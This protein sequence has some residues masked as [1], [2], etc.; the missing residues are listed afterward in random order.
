MRAMGDFWA[1]ITQ[2]KREFAYSAG[3]KFDVFAIASGL[4]RNGEAT[5]WPSKRVVAICQHRYPSPDRSAFTTSGPVSIFRSFIGGN[6]F[7]IG[8]QRPGPI[9]CG[10]VSHNS[11]AVNT[12][13]LG[14]ERC[15]RN[16]SLS[17]QW[18]LLVLLVVWTRMWSAALL[19]LVPVWSARKCLARIQQAQPWPVLPS[20][21][22]VMTQASAAHH[23]D[24][25]APWGAYNL[26]PPSGMSPGGGFVFG[27]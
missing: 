27:D 22:C 25:I 15:K 1:A 17:L 18:P 12:T 7:D 19:A 13:R 16:Q 11:M 24:T 21:C 20:A 26:R 23:G 9:E 8:Y 14:K 4:L 10:S 3:A 2:S 6:R 5:S